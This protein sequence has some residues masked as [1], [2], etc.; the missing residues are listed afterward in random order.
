MPIPKTRQAPAVISKAMNR[1]LLLKL[2]IVYQVKQ[3]FY[4][5]LLAQETL[6]YVRQDLE[7]SQDYLDKARLKYEAG[8]VA[9]VEVGLC[10]ASTEMRLTASGGG[11]AVRFGRVQVKSRQGDVPNPVSVNFGNRMEL[12]GYD[13]DRRVTKPAED[14]TLTLY[15]RA[16]QKMELNYSISAQLVGDE[17]VKV[18]ED[19]NWPLK[20]D[21]PTALWEPGHLLGDPK[22]LTVRADAAP[23]TY[24]I[25]VTVYKKQDEELVYLPVISDRGEMLVNHITLTS[26]RVQP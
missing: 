7:L 4:G 23:G 13:L 19:S 16:L 14:I 20:G 8:D 5:L 15:W 25:Q 22:R 24:D 21:A 1:L 9:Q 3:A 17:Q 11:D 26:V 18:A 2:D 12:V 6:R 10:D